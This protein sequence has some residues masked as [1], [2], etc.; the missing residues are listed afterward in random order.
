MPD[1]PNLLLIDDDSLITESL[2]FVLRDTFTVHVA[3]TRNGARRLLQTMPKVPDLALVDLGLPP[4]PHSPEQGFMMVTELLTFNPGIKILVLS[5]QDSRENVLHALTLGAVDFIPKPCDIELLKT[6]LTHQLMIIKAEQHKPQV[7]KPECGL[8]GESPAMETLRAQIRQ[9]ADSPFAVLIEGES[10]VGKELVAQCLHTQ[11]QHANAPCL[12]V[13]CAAFTAELLGAQLFGHAKGAFTG[14]GTARA[15]F[16]EE[17]DKGSLILDE[18]GEM[19]LELQS[20]LLRVLENGEYYRLGETRVRKSAT[21][22]IAASN[23]DLRE[24]VRSGRFRGDLYHRL[25][26]LTIKVPSLGERG[27]DKFMIMKHF[28]D[29][30]ANMGTLFQLDEAASERWGRYNFPGNV[31]ELRNI[32]IRLG[33]KYPN[34]MIDKGQLEDE[35]EADTEM[36]AQEFREIGPN[37]TIMEELNQGAFSLDDT[38]LEWERRY[39]NAALKTSAGNLSQAARLLG[40]NRT[41]LYSK[42]QRLTK[43]TN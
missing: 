16:F 8:I 17:A 21:R 15:G 4:D 31:R 20:K 5:G 23:R 28:Q 19:P 12:T 29:F 38:L 41:T 30:Y 39:I 25:S 40:I 14:A 27:E 36:E 13:N 9:F 1:L 33:V 6:R 10:G 34:Q 7:K 26:V 3:P 2:A 32:V 37:E 35:L 18:I 22:V 42:M 43:G 24:E 11:S